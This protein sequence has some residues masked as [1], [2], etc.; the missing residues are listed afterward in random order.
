MKK[1]EARPEPIALINENALLPDHLSHHQQAT[2]MLCQVVKSN[3]V[4]ALSD[5]IDTN[6]LTEMI[7]MAVDMSSDVESRRMTWHW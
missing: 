6:T 4:N 1:G 2:I 7:G 3:Q 5:I